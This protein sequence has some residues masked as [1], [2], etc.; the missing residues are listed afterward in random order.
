MK[1]EIKQL[2]IAALRSGEYQ[3]GIGA[4]RKV[5]SNGTIHHCCLGVL[6]DLHRIETGGHWDRYTY[7]GS[8]GFLPDEV[9][10]WADLPDSPE[11]L[12]KDLNDFIT[13]TALNDGDTAVCAD[14]RQHSFGQIA[15]LI[16][17]HL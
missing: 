17:Q 6:C 3:Q 2:W 4:L 12:D 16:E 5:D 11:I 10:D 13:L 1:A 8:E 9:A 14:I 15:D 7:L